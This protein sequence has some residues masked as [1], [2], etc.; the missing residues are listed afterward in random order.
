MK[1]TELKKY[2]VA[3]GLN[4]DVGSA[5]EDTEFLIH[6][7]TREKGT[8]LQVDAYGCA[9][10]KPMYTIFS[11]SEDFIM[12][13]YERKR[14]SAALLRK[15][16]FFDTYSVWDRTGREYRNYPQREY[17]FDS[18]ESMLCGAHFFLTPGV[19]T[20][21]ALAHHQ[22]FVRAA[23]LE[24][25]HRAKRKA[26]DRIMNQAR[27]L[28][29]TFQ[30][31]VDRVPL[32]KSR[33]IYYKR[34]S[35]NACGYCTVC[36]ADVII[37]AG[38]ARH[39]QTGICPHCNQNIMFKATGI[40]KHVRDFVR[41]EYVQRVD[42]NSLM[43]REFDITKDYGEDYRHPEYFQ[44]EGSRHIIHPDGKREKYL[45]NGC[46]YDWLGDW[47][48]KNSDEEFYAWLYT[49]NLHAVLNGTLWQYSGIAAY[50]KKTRAFAATWYLADSL[51]RPCLEYLAKMGFSRLLDEKYAQSYF[52]GN[53]ANWDGRTL[54]DVLKLSKP[55]IRIACQNNVD[56]KTLG[57]LQA[58]S[59]VDAMPSSDEMEWFDRN[60]ADKEP[61]AY[62]LRYMSIHKV[63]KYADYVIQKGHYRKI[64]DV[65]ND[66]RDY[67]ENAELLGYNLHRNPVLFPPNLKK[68]HDSLMKLVKVK[69]DGIV[70]RRLSELCQDM[71]DRYGFANEDYIV[72]AP[73]CLKDLI[74]EGEQLDHCVAKN[75]Y[76]TK[77]VKGR[78]VILFIRK[79][80]EP[81]KPFVTVEVRDGC[82]AQI[83]AFKD[84]DPDK[85]VLDFVEVWKRKV[86]DNPR[87]RSA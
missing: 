71:M 53:T 85:N 56:F 59:K 62:L 66:W 82:I 58:L 26:I 84:Y 16:G 83:R 25:R 8:V 64:N 4:L 33:Y 37:P 1:K 36:G 13:E 49:P 80:S 11:T 43:I 7:E 69:E 28:P 6:A 17:R 39:N 15:R 52:Y 18:E 70:D 50:A 76:G 19:D 20:I 45:P 87:R 38:Q 34:H 46:T 78:C 10:G 55:F 51:K 72:R 2:L 60:G 68:S 65:M 44:Y 24:S 9:A 23:A 74:L 27:P 48:R 29:A 77:M 54:S 61:L 35:A 14:W 41:V 22:Q 86:L 57:I 42:E 31:W 75:G 12:W 5:E 73:S 32:Q 47:K 79:A 67:L 30:E 81:E 40:S 63:Q 3:E 21:C